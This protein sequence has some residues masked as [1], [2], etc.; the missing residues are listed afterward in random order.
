MIARNGAFDR[1]MVH[2][3]AASGR[4][5][6]GRS[7]RWIGLVRVIGSRPRG[8]RVGGRNWAKTPRIPRRPFPAPIGAVIV[9]GVDWVGSTASPRCRGAVSHL[10]LYNQG[11]NDM[12]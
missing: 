5:N 3:S 10:H 7:P 6:S 2:T 12:A 1:G 4:R 9:P 11:V 8:V